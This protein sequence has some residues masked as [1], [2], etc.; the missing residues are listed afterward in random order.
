MS[1][2]LKARESALKRKDFL[3]ATEN[4]ENI[5][6]DGEDEEKEEVNKNNNNNN[7]KMKEQKKARKRE[8]Q[9]VFGRKGLEESLF[10]KYETAG[11]NGDLYPFLRNL[12]KKILSGYEKEKYRTI[13]AHP[14]FYFLLAV[15]LLSSSILS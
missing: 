10:L 11:L 13:I 9:K 14:L 2:R 15:S 12:I 5:E 4:E 7:K 3:L 8:W 1:K 6:D